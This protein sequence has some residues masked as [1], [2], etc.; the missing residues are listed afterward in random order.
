M[1]NPLIVPMAAHVAWAAFLYVLL[2]IP[3]VI[4]SRLLERRYG[5]KRA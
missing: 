2:F 5:W 3:L 4:S 1:P